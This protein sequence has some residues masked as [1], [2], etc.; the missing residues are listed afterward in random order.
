[1]P[2]STSAL[3][4][5]QDFL[6]MASKGVS[7]RVNCPVCDNVLPVTHDLAGAGVQCTRCKATLR[8]EFKRPKT[9]SLHVVG[10]PAASWSVRGPELE[11]RDRRP[12]RPD[13]RP[14]GRHRASACESHGASG[15]EVSK[16]QPSRVKRSPDVS[17]C[18]KGILFLPHGGVRPSGRLVLHRPRARGS[19]SGGTTGRRGQRSIGGEWGRSLLGG[20]D[21]ALPASPRPGLRAVVVNIA[22][23]TEKKKWLESAVRDFLKTPAGKSIKINLLGMRPVEGASAILDGPV[24]SAFP[25]P[26]IHVW[27]PASTNDRKLL[28]DQWRLTHHGNPILL[29]ENV[30]RTPL[31]FVMWK[32]RHDEFIKKYTNLNFRVVAEAMSVPGGWAEIARKPDWGLFKFGHSDP[33]TSHSGLQML[34][35]M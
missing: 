35:L 22:Y 11:D 10:R 6:G 24:P 14:A 26:P 4:G 2:S 8:V 15:T 5:A 20:R 33:R 21:A 18:R 34:V 13:A 23:D 17:A 28:D 29:A 32:Q 16:P 19:V 12:V 30:V 7:G 31:V 3:K 9:L 1:M 25:H 27:S